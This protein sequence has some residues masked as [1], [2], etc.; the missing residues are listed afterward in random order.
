MSKDQVWKIISFLYTN[1][2]KNYFSRHFQAAKWPNFVPYFFRLSRNLHSRTG[3]SVMSHY[4]HA[5]GHSSVNSA[6]QITVEFA[7]ES[8]QLVRPSTLS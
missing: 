5:G 6:V 2:S 4:T 3:L 7:L 8:D 1:R